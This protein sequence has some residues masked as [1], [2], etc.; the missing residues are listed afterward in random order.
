MDWW[1]GLVPLLFSCT[2]SLFGFVF[3]EEELHCQ[4][5]IAEA[6]LLLDHVPVDVCHQATAIHLLSLRY[7]RLQTWIVPPSLVRTG[8]WLDLGLV[9]V[10]RVCGWLPFLKSTRLVGICL[11]LL[12]VVVTFFFF[13]LKIVDLKDKFTQKLNTHHPLAPVQMEVHANFRKTFLERHSFLLHHWSRWGLVLKLRKTPRKRHEVAPY[14][15]SGVIQDRGSSEIPD[16]FEKDV[17]YNLDVWLSLV[18]RFR[19]SARWCF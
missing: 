12:N 13:L 14:S 15:S 17:I 6:F 10:L 1:I 5:L 2:V 16:W 7:S 11:S 3:V 19:W 9:L 4:R 8:K 18:T